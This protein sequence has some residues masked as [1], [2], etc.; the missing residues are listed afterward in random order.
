MLRHPPI[1][2][3]RGATTTFA[4][5]ERSARPQPPRRFVFAG[6]SNLDP[7]KDKHM[8]GATLTIVDADHI[9]IEG[10]GWE[11]GQPAKEMCGKMKLIRK[12]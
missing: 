9:E 3:A 7:K 11:D 10:E 5:G 2:P 12:K 8:H 4:G 6:G 1:E